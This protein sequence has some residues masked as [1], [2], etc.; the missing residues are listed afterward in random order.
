MDHRERNFWLSVLLVLIVSLAVLLLSSHRGHGATI[1]ETSGLSMISDPSFEGPFEPGTS[2]LVHWLGMDDVWGWASYPAKWVPVLD[3]DYAAY[4]DPFAADTTTMTNDTWLAPGSYVVG[5]WA[6]YRRHDYDEL[7]LVF[8]FTDGQEFVADL[9]PDGQYHYYDAD[10]DL[11]VPARLWIGARGHGDDNLLV[12]AVSVV[13]R[14]NP[15]PEPA[16]W[17]FLGGGVVSVLIL[18]GAGRGSRLTNGAG[19]P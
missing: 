19:R 5:M 4:C 12:D 15:A 18:S 3:G 10:V 14:G 7:Q 11:T 8:G 1:P 17:M 6:N 16:V 13:P 2:E 9:P